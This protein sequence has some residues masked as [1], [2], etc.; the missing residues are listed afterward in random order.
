MATAGAAPALKV[1]KSTLSMFLRTRCDK[2]LFLSLHDRRQM[3]SAGL[4]APIKRPGIGIL[5]VEG[6]EFELDRN[7]A[8]VRLFPGMVDFSKSSATYNDMDLHAT[9]SGL[10]TAPRLILQGSFSV[11]SQQPA[12]LSRIGLSAADQSLIPPLAD[13]IPD[14][15]LVRDGLDGDM[16]VCPDGTR[17]AFDG[18][19]DD[20]Y[21]LVILD[22][23]HTAESNPSYCSE[24]ALYAVMLANW[25]QLHPDLARRYFVCSKAYLWTR[26]K[27]T[28]SRLSELEKAGG[29]TPSQ[30]LDALI[31]DSEDA[32]LRFYLASIR[33]FFEDVARVI[34]IGHARP[35]GWQDLDWHVSGSCGSCDWLGD[36][37][38]MGQSQRTVV[39]AQPGHYC[40]PSA[41]A[42]GH[43]CLVP[44]VTR[45]AKKV[46]LRN[47]VQDTTALAGAVGHAAFQQHTLLK[48]EAKTL[49]ARSA[50]IQSNALTTDPDS[51]IASLV[52]G[53]NL[54]L[55]A[56]INFDSS[57][58]LLTGL[59]LSGVATNFTPGH[60]PR[61]FGAVPF[62]VDQKSHA[63][64]WVALEGFLSQIASCIDVAE[65]LVGSEVTGQIHFWEQRQFVE[66]CNAMGRHLPRV[67]ALGDK[68]AKALAWVFAPDSML[69]RP[70]SLAAATVVAVDEIVRRLV[71]APTRHVITL[72]DTVDYYRRS[73]VSPAERDS[74]YREYL[75]NG[76]PRERIYEIWSNA[77]MVKRGATNTVPR[78]TVISQYSDALEKQSRALEA[79][80]EKLRED[81][82]G[83]FRA[84]ATRIPT[85]IP[86]GARS[87]AFDGKLW[88][89]FDELDFNASQLEAHMRLSMDGER[90]EAS[91]EA[92]VL[93]NGA[94]L[95]DDHYVFD[96]RPS[97]SEAK[98]RENA[99][100]TLGKLGE[101]GMPLQ[102]GRTL[103]RPGAPLYSGDADKLN[104]PLWSLIEARLVSFDRV[105]SR[106]QVQL[107]VRE[108]EHL[109][110]YL[111]ANSV[112]P[113]LHEVFLVEPKSPSAFNWAEQCG[114]I[115][116]AIGTPKIAQP[117]RN[118]AAAIG[119][120]LPKSK[121]VSPETPAARVLWNAAALESKVVVP[122]A[123]ARSVASDVGRLDGLND[124]Q[125]KAAAFAIER[126]LTLIW[127]PPG[128]GKT[129]TLAAIIHG[130]ARHAAAKNQPLRV[131][132][133]GPTYKA[134]EEVM[135]RAARAM[136]ADSA[137]PG[138]LYMGYTAGRAIAT[139][140][141]ALADH[142]TYNAME[143]DQTTQSMQNCL[144]ALTAGSG[145]TIAGCHISQA[146]RFPKL[147][148]G[149][150]LA[151]VFDVIVIDE[152]SQVPVSRAL[153]AL[154]GLRDD[155]R[156]IVAGDHL[157]MPPIASIEPPADAAYLVGSIQT[158][159]TDR[160]FSAPL[161]SRELQV[162]YR[163]GAH[164][165][166]FAR[167]IGYPPSLLPQYPDARLHRLLPLPPRT[168][169]P[170]H[171]PWSDQYEL[172]LRPET[173]VATLLHEDDVSSQGN[174]FEARLVAS[175]VVL[176]R[177]TVSADLHAYG[178]AAPNHRAPI[179]A[180]FWGKCVGVVTPHRAQRALVV[181]ELEKLYPAEADLIADA[182]D[183]VERFQ[184]GERHTIIVTFGVADVDVIGGEEA[185][186][187]QLQ[188]TNVAVSRAMGKCIVVMPDALA[189]HIPE[190]K[191][192]LATAHAL[193]D[194]VE[195]FCN[196]RVDT[197]FQL[198][199][200]SRP[201]QVRYRG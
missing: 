72:F 18:M 186:L 188:R 110:P 70:E 98:F 160:K 32:Q 195:E 8:L 2:E 25:L 50:A 4:P 14:V 15:V 77:T 23:K 155:A 154:A 19:L 13:Y 133:T 148:T 171:L 120:P 88:L 175:I 177:L 97:S 138:S 135:E 6:K 41:A 164:I 44:G 116:K 103:L 117:D 185:F 163:S 38:H 159:L 199:A 35:R 11:A 147:I 162:N 93:L 56:S 121:A 173:V 43:L 144:A 16:E 22:I 158:Y 128:T 146:R 92:I 104:R 151:Q 194:Y 74:Y 172:L 143:F 108:E 191:R 102:L 68:R 90:L 47:T 179:P 106:A 184:G 100:L 24:I 84:K 27:Q 198:G 67:M 145:V 1:S 30:L 115:L 142:V 201:G 167:S 131:L 79:V 29:A 101:P 124:S 129:K 37:R 51:I 192:A 78:N 123:T 80:C 17:K 99:R 157:Q 105:G 86:Q 165:V 125:E 197:S 134:V 52:S 89:W 33:R 111:I 136:S 118:A 168:M 28:E 170:V 181:R 153:A 65:N 82:K 137:A 31:K 140:P 49:P 127:G 64:E 126:G 76:I 40:M 58:G 150:Y 42:S 187:M 45:G 132:V 83:K 183:T 119:M 176:L 39:D 113:L 71:F 61:R 166:D 69:A 73:T 63:A 109:V 57:A 21:A 46:L 5:A 95:Q 94:H 20:R 169:F 85:S 36:K 174:E 114:P 48:R 91:Y 200:E 182:I 189:A 196:V 55:Y 10:G 112:Y 156:L 141:S 60:S 53:A 81:Y 87:V 161:N 152:S 130:V 96:V 190:D 193:K 178:S 26:V 180:E 62:V 3:A 107:S 122:I 149:N 139:G 59:A 75:N 9:L 7:D 54:L 66:L 34:R 12:V